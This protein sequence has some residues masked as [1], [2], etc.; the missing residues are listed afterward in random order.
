MV[1]RT[2]SDALTPLYQ[3]FFCD[4]SFSFVSEDLRRDF[5]CSVDLLLDKLQ[6]RYLL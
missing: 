2:E 3:V 6:H 5:Y 1:S 4:F